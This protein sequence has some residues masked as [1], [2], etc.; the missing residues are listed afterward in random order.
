MRRALRVFRHQKTHTQCVGV[1]TSWWCVMPKAVGRHP[2]QSLAVRIN[3]VGSHLWWVEPRFRHAAALE[4]M[5][6]VWLVWSICRHRHKQLQF[7]SNSKLH[8][9][10]YWRWCTL[11]IDGDKF[12][13]Q[14]DSAQFSCL[15]LAPKSLRK[16]SACSS[17]EV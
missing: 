1:S 17:A 4:S 9:I 7:R 16:K 8:D 2:L 10:S 14:C 11:A 13:L 5:E 12:H 3:R 6:D 15:R